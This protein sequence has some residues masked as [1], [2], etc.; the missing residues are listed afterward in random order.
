MAGN[1]GIKEKYST[2]LALFANA[3]L[4]SKE[5]TKKPIAQRLNDRLYKNPE[6]G[7][8]EW[9][10]FTMPYGHGRIG[11]RDKVYLTHRISYELHKGNIPI[12]MNVC[13]K[14]DNPKCCN[15]NHLFLGTQK[16]NMLDAW[17][18]G[19]LSILLPMLGEKNPLAKLTNKQA[20]QI[21]KRLRHGEKGVDL[22]KEFKVSQTLISRIKLSKTY[23]NQAIRS[24]Y[25]Y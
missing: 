11:F 19:R 2:E 18:K 8:W 17:K 15:P 3:S 23:K 12:G 6:N 7:C 25:G 16:D 10:G 21:R 5:R 22:A 20:K 1:N 24:V 4:R 9:L 14:C 13:H